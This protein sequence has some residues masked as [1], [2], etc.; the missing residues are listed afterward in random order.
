MHMRAVIK[1]PRLA[2]LVAIP[3]RVWHNAGVE[4][5]DR[6][7]TRTRAKGVDADGAPFA[8]YSEGYAKAK[9]KRS[10]LSTVGRVN[11]TGVR[12]GSRMLDTMLVKASATQ[13]PR[14][15]IFFSLAEKAEIA[16]YHMGEGR[17]DREFFALSDADVDAI[18]ARVRQGM[19]QK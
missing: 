13:N 10:K 4:A 11:L 8:P 1:G 3:P 9:A 12:A 2:D 16:S 18:V 5:R 6:I 15:T 17:V 7:R 14:I 19:G